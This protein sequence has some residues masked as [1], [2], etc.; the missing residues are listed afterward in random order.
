MS[1]KYGDRLRERFPS[2]KLSAA[3]V[4]SWLLSKAQPL[5][6]QFTYATKERY[7]SKKL[8]VV[9]VFADI[10]WKG[11]PKGTAYYLNRARKVAALYKG[12]L[13]FALA[14]MS[15]YE[16]TLPDYGL[17]VRVAARMF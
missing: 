1:E 12:K 16:Y 7:L 10:D 4:K 11:N 8:P 13:Q 14:H 2:A 5:V 17:E 15:D 9:L 6:A 3:A